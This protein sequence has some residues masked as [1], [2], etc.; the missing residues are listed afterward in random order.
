MQR[1]SEDSV[2]DVC[3]G[4]TRFNARVG[5]DKVKVKDY[6]WQNQSLATDVDRLKRLNHLHNEREVRKDAWCF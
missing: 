5:G 1:R 6:I 2:N 3:E 4:V